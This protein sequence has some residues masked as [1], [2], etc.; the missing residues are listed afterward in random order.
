MSENGT[1][2][3]L[4]VDFNLSE[5]DPIEFPFLPA[6]RGDV[7]FENSRGVFFQAVPA[8]QSS[9]SHVQKPIGQPESVR[10]DQNL[11]GK[12]IVRAENKGVPCLE[13]PTD[14][15]QAAPP[16]LF[17]IYVVNA[18]EGKKDIVKDV[19]FKAEITGIHR[20]EVDAFNQLARFLDH[21][22]N[23]VDACNGMSHSFEK[24][25]RSPATAADVED[26][27]RNFKMGAENPLLHREKIKSAVLL[28]RLPA[29]KGFFVP[30]F[31]L[32]QIHQILFPFPVAIS[33]L[34]DFRRVLKGF[35]GTNR[36]TG[37]RQSRAQKFSVH[38]HKAES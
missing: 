21:L 3:G 35:F 30:Q 15:S 18:V 1:I 14:L 2:R 23:E 32:S 13:N 20:S 17:G 25:A 19:V 16:F 28:D 10:R 37:R 29:G 9:P 5:T 8:K 4:T 38:L 34:Q 36:R 27:T 33:I 7:G 31:L 22:R 11:K 6:W 24:E 12:A 26:P